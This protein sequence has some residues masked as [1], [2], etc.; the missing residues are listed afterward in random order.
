MSR[1]S[2]LIPFT[3]SHM[4]FTAEIA[5][6]PT[7]V[8]VASKNGKWSPGQQLYHVILCLRPIV[9]ALNAKGYLMQKFGNL[10]RVSNDFNTV[11]ELYKS[12]L[13]SGGKAPD[14]YVPDEVLLSER[15]QY[16]Q[17]MQVLLSAISESLN[18]YTDEELDT[19]I[20]PHPL[21]G[22]LAISEMF[23]LMTYHA[24][25]HLEQTKQNL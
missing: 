24:S 1:Q 20:M 3:E 15:T 2:I 19:I 21:L 12:A 4:Q 6:L 8:F 23:Y 11:V 9:K 22:N 25:H 13:N 14:Q 5:G 10:K 16:L 17:E 7:D 18:S